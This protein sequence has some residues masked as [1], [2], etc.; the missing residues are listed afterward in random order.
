M[1]DHDAVE[2]RPKWTPEEEKEIEA[3]VEELR[4]NVSALKALRDRLGV[5]QEELAAALGVTQS[6]VSKMEARAE[7]RL[8][9]LRRLVEHKGGRLRVVADFGDRQLDLPV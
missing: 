9:V 6:N 1:S 7:P 5:T 8:S 3:G 2:W 4:R